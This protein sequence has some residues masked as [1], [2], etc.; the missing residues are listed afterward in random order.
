MQLVVIPRGAPV[1]AAS[2]TARC[3]EDD[4]PEPGWIVPVS[5]IVRLGTTPLVEITGVPLP[6]RPWRQPATDQA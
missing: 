6:Q 1:F 5:Y 2:A 4:L 3:R